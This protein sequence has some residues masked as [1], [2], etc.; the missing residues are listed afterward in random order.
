MLPLTNCSLM[1]AECLV[2][3]S[4]IIFDSSISHPDLQGRQ[5][6]SKN[7][8]HLSPG[9]RGART[10]DMFNRTLEGQVGPARAPKPSQT[11]SAAQHDEGMLKTS[12][13]DNDADTCKLLLV[14]SLEG[15]WASC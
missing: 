14:E 6:G 10:P 5:H 3:V 2:T 11:M 1:R 12:V 9:A 13:V 8:R 7:V 4:S 15:P